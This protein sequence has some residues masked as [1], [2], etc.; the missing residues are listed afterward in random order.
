[1]KNKLTLQ[2]RT[3][4]LEPSMGVLGSASGHSPRRN[5]TSLSE[6]V[7]QALK[8]DIIRGV[9][10]PGEAL[11]EK[12]LA[13]R[14]RGSRTPVREAAVR[15]QEENL[16]RIIANRGYFITQITIQ[17]I[18]EIY[19]FR[20]G[21][22]GTSAELAAQSNQDQSAMER[23]EELAQTEHGGDDRE[24]HVRFIET[25]T[26]FHVLIAQLTRNPLLIRAVADMRCQMERIMY[27][28]LDVGYYGEWPIREHCGIFEAI[29]KHDAQLAR[30]RMCEH[31]Y[32]SKDKVLQV[33]TR[34]SRLR[35]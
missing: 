12:D 24:S 27:A 3:S 7:Y 9:F 6:R 4:S 18:N 34:G 35:N 11:S 15:L 8:R 13:K 17:N 26:E 30:K 32:I 21:V 22:E 20:A 25:D 10:Q 23:L 16:M 2:P 29:Q 19:D 5:N 31:I 1:M 14:Y 28:S 33:A